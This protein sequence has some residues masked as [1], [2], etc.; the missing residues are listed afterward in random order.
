[1]LKCYTKKKLCD[2]DWK[3][4]AAHGY[5]NIPKNVEVQYIEEIANCYGR[6]AKVQWAGIVYYV[7]PQDLKWRQV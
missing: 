3:T 4:Q 1:M 5:P 6:Y 7:K 2:E